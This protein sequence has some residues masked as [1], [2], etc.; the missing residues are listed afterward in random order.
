MIDYTLS[1]KSFKW[2]LH[3]RDYEGKKHQKL[4]KNCKTK[5][6]AEACALKFSVLEDDQYLIRNITK[7]MYIPGSQHLTRLTTLGKKFA[8]ETLYQKRLQIE[9]MVKQFGDWDIRKLKV[10]DVE[11][12]LMQDELHSGAWKNNIIDT[13]ATVYDETIW[14]CDTQVKRPRFQRFSRNSRKSDIFTMQELDIILKPDVW[15]SY[16]DFLA[17]YLI[18]ACGLRIGELRA[19][20]V[21]QIFWT[22]KV[23]LINGFCKQ[24]GFRTDY[25]KKGS[26][27]DKK[28]RLAPLSDKLL[29]MLKNYI[30]E[31]HRQEN[32][33]LFY[34]DIDS[35]PVSKEHLYNQLRGILK[36]TKIYNP[37]R[38]LVPHS[39]RFTYVT[40][41]RSLL[42][43]EQVRLIVGHST[44]SMTDY[45]TRFSLQNEIRGIKDSFSAVNK[46]F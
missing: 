7:D 26:E 30:E 5:K 25:N 32:D 27:E 39:F 11:L 2:Y 33:F 29:V 12:F 43:S 3:Y 35:K 40:Y 10:R 36:R 21:S 28:I 16:D 31:N 45:Y 18:A 22:E 14:K 9:F 37:D 17:F 13:F 44:M 15:K 34:N 38:K 42:E 46:I 4:L 41:M 1:K 20:R 6:E 8:D 24:D 23:L 19:I